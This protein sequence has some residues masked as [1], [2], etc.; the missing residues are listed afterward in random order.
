MSDLYRVLGVAHGADNELIKGAFRRLAKTCHPD[1]Y[2][3]DKR[4]EQRFKEIHSAYETL[5]NPENRAAYD[6]VCAE[7][8]AMARRRFR[9]AA[10]TLSA[11]FALT[12][13]SGLFACVW[14][15]RDG[16]L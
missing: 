5:R 13:C 16:L 4:A 3:G 10:A 14:L 2:G 9:S 1:L 6:A 7:R 12:V 8:R 11:S 15:M